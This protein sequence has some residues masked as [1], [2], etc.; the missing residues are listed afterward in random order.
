MAHRR[1]IISLDKDSINNPPI[2]LRQGESGLQAYDIEFMLDGTTVV[3]KD[4]DVVSFRG[5]TSTD[6]YVSELCT[7]K[8]GLVTF[9][10][11]VAT[12][13]AGN[14]KVAYFSVNDIS[15]S[16][17][18]IDV[19]VLEQADPTAEQAQVYVGEVTKLIND[20]TTKTNAAIKNL[21]D[22]QGALDTKIADSEKTL[23]ANVAAAKKALDTAV[24]NAN[25][26]L[27]DAIALLNKNVSD[28]QEK[29]DQLKKDLAAADFQKY[30]LTETD[31]R[32]KKWNN[33]IDSTT[34]FKG[35][36]FGWYE[37]SPT[38]VTNITDY[39]GIPEGY[40][41]I[42]FNARFERLDTSNTIVTLAPTLSNTAPPRALRVVKIWFN[43]DTGVITDTRE[44]AS[45]S[46]ND[47]KY[48]IAQN[49]TYNPTLDNKLVKEYTT[50]VPFQIRLINGV[51][52]INSI[53]TPVK[54]IPSST[55]DTII[56]S[57]DDA[58]YLPDRKVHS[59][60]QGSGSNTFLFSVLKT[61]EIA[62]SR[63]RS[64]TKE[65]LDF[66]VGAWLNA[67]VSYAPK[68]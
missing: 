6:T 17:N 11:K 19:S 36:R 49:E 12:S 32:A 45:E 65:N 15:G 21:T 35:H 41:K 22:K 60:Q 64:L 1:L 46:Q 10:P 13:A 54:V 50:G 7:V 34:F 57:I 29:M 52:V 16:G 18:N 61:G 26:T 30:P 40:R 23:A 66:A 14:Y 25:K 48:Q 67:D 20:L 51:C 55:A 2:V 43:S 24:A 3:I 8:G 5:T 68:L 63:H 59:L 56:G 28:A 47:A 38:N 37:I 33:I 27:T 39:E 31:G 9:T 42:Y 4:T 62:I 44:Y 58:R 53:F